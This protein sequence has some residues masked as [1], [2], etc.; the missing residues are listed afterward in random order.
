M[1]SGEFLMKNVMKNV[2]QENL[3]M[4]RYFAGINNN[5]KQTKVNAYV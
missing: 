4:A 2:V 5:N 1:V 3:K